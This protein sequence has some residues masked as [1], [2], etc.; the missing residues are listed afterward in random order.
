VTENLANVGVRNWRSRAK[1]EK[2]WQES[3]EEAKAY[4][5]LLRFCCR[6][7]WWW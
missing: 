4:P 3:I 5:E 2:K 6:W 1:D 7:W